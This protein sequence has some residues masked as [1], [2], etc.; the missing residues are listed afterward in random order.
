MGD[1]RPYHDAVQDISNYRKVSKPVLSDFENL[2]DAIVG[3]EET[4]YALS[5]HEQV[6][7]NAG[8]LE[9]L[10]NLNV[11]G[12]ED[13]PGGGELEDQLDHSE[14]VDVGVVDGE[15]DGDEPGAALQPPVGLQLHEQ[16]LCHI[17]FKVE[18]LN[19]ASTLVGCQ[20]ALEGNLIFR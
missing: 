19:V 13:A 1:G 14:E 11:V 9:Q 6:V 17:L 7:S 5:G 20:F 16:S 12:G 18:V 15:V 8:I 3:N 10:D 4:E 2:L